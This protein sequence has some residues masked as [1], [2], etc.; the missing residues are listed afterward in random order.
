MRELGEVY[1]AAMNK[2]SLLAA[3]L[4][5]TACGGDG[6]GVQSATEVA[7]EVTTGMRLDVRRETNFKV[8]SPG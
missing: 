5:L 2:R 6:P 1:I 8:Y 3:L 4:L 7:R